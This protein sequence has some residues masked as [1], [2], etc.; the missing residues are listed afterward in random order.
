MKIDRKLLLKNTLFNFGGQIASLL[1]ALIVVPIVINFLGIERYGILAILWSVLSYFAIFELGLSS[2]IIK[3][4]AELFLKNDRKQIP[5]IFWTTLI[6]QAIFGIVAGIILYLLIPVILVK[7]FKIPHEFI[8]ETKVA[9]CMLAVFIPINFVSNSFFAILSAS[10]RFDL[11]NLFKIPS[12]ISTHIVTII[13]VLAG[14]NLSGIIMSIVVVKILV[15]IILVYVCFKTYPYLKKPCFS[16]GHIRKIYLYGSWLTVSN[17]INPIVFYLDRFVIGAILSMSAVA[18]YSAPFQISAKLWII[19][20]S[21]MMTLMP[22]FSSFSS[23]E[24]KDRLFVLFVKS[25]KYMFLISLPLIFTGIVYSRDILHIWIGSDFAQKSFIPLIILLLS[26]LIDIPGI[27]SST[28]LEGYGKTKSLAKIKMLFFVPNFLIMYFLVLHYNIIGAA[29]S[30]FI[31]RM[32][33]SSVFFLVALKAMGKSFREVLISISG[34]VKLI[35][36]GGAF[37]GVFIFTDIPY[38]KFIAFVVLLALVTI[39]WIYLFEDK[40]K[41]FFSNAFRKKVKFIKGVI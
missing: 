40:E 26:N 36:V 15:F 16:R 1:V 27:I 21:M 6:L 32:L 3:F 23:I 28:F 7:L 17:A 38:S 35:S 19:S 11:V 37:T 8:P 41:D 22:A 33:Y 24:N 2:A 13:C 10:Q 31:C 14:F 25:L 34:V 5:E 39:E 30:V 29:I 12:N 9:L 18:Y 4:S 20:S